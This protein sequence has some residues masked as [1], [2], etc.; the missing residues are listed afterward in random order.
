MGKDPYEGL[1]KL[2]KMVD[3]GLRF[4][5]AGEGQV[6]SR[7]ANGWS[8]DAPDADGDVDP[9]TDSEYIEDAQDEDEVLDDEDVPL[10]EAD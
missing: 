7:L 3:D 8:K 2:Y 9:D 6:E 10:D 4:C 1:I 5:Y